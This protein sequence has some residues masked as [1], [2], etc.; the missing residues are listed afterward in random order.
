MSIDDVER[1]K[2][3]ALP[4]AVQTGCG[5]VDRVV[6]LK[7]TYRRED[8]T[9]NEEENPQMSRD[10]RSEAPHEASHGVMNGVADPLLQRVLPISSR[11]PAADA[12]IEP[13]NRR[14]GCLDR[15]SKRIVVSKDS[16]VAESPRLLQLL[17]GRRPASSAEDLE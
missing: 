13:S 10:E 1:R 6:E 2:H 16:P 9:V 3:P 14:G 8:E 4:L 17:L 5:S 15:R 11:R 12:D 7:A